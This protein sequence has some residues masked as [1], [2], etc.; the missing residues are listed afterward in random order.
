M[1]IRNHCYS[2][3]SMN[4]HILKSGHLPI[5]PFL[6]CRQ[7]I[8]SRTPPQ[9]MACSCYQKKIAEKRNV[10]K[11]HVYINVRHIISNTQFLFA[12]RQLILTRVQCN[13][14][15]DRNEELFVLSDCLSDVSAGVMHHWFQ[16]YFPHSRWNI[17]DILDLYV[18]I[19]F[20]LYDKRNTYSNYLF[21][22]LWSLHRIEMWCIDATTQSH[23]EKSIETSDW[24]HLHD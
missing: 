10:N 8:V 19:L 14:N 22:N 3:L 2:L 7:L 17:Q 1:V 6:Q 20:I 24:M 18:K 5:N 23:T 15:A 11:C 16:Q 13:R 9:W 21:V 12:I 4:E